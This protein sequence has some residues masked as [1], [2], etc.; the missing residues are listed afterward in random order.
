MM[1]KIACPFN[2]FKIRSARFPR[3]N[4]TTLNAVIPAA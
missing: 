3:F 2:I 4:H 1:K